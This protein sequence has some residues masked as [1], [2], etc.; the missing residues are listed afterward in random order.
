[1]TQYNSLNIK[2]SNSQLNKLKSA[3]KRKTEVVLR[4]SPTMIGD[5][6]DE[7]NFPHKLLITD[8]QVSHLRNAFSN[9]SSTDIILSKTQLSRMIQLGGFLG[10]LLG[11]L[12]KT[13]L[14]LI[15]NV[16]KPLA[17]SVL[18][19]LGLTAAASAA[20]AE[21]HKKIL[22][23]GKTTLIISNDEMEDIMKIVNSLEDSGIL[24]KGVSETVQNEVKEQ[25]GE[26]LGMLLGTL[27]ASLLENILP[28]RGTKREGEG[29]V[30]AGEGNKSNK[31]DI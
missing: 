18:I 25:K 16:L 28:G 29:I 1:M 6:N 9:N 27:G 20:D 15:K 31:M 30:R 14:P 22:G 17:K 12:L 4:L 26:F 5:S 3:I 10:R 11:P 8:R 2:L 13:G 24:L 23:S 7:I 19:P 21:I